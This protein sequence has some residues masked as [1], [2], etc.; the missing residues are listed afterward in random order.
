MQCKMVCS[1]YITYPAGHATCV[2]RADC[3]HQLLSVL[4]APSLPIDILRGNVL[5]DILGGLS[6][7][8]T[9]QAHS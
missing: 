7:A 1:V 5:S 3:T 8:S 4:I 9:R 6:M 2:M